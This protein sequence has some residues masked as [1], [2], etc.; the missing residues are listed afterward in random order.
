MRPA[1][2]GDRIAR[3]LAR[4][5]V[6]VAGPMRGRTLALLVAIDG[7]GWI[8]T[9]CGVGPAR[10]GLLGAA[11]PAPFVLHGAIALS[12]TVGALLPLL[13]AGIGPPSEAA[14][15]MALAPVVG[16][17]RADDRAARGL[18]RG[19]SCSPRRWRCCERV[20]AS[21]A[22]P[23]APA[24]GRESRARRAATS[25]RT[26]A[27]SS[28]FRPTRAQVAAAAARAPRADGPGAARRRQ[29][30]RRHRRACRRVAAARPW[31]HV[32]HRA[33]TD[34]LGNG[35]PRRLRLVPATRL[36][37]HRPDGLRPLPH[38]REACRAARGPARA[39][40]AI[41]LLVVV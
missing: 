33:E 30:A 35:L 39:R 28:S 12:L 37:G 24:P 34:G 7:L 31:M 3:W 8:A 11:A 13:P 17:E 26:S 40:L 36:R 5:G 25:H 10:D 9:G 14:L 18:L 1:L 27:R 2:L 38:A 23:A 20:A 32:L 22:S 4:R 41:C 6:A 21:A 16:P 29:L 15:T 19:A